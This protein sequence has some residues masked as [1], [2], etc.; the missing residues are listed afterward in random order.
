MNMGTGVKRIA[1]NR[2]KIADGATD[3]FHVHH[4]GNTITAR[5]VFID[6]PSR[7]VYGEPE[8][9]AGGARAYVVTYAEVEC[10]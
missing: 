5:E 3:V 4:K 6:G 7:L 8:P 9:K 2:K 1:I 10:E